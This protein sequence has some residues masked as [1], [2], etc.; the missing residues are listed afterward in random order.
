MDKLFFVIWCPQ[1]HKPVTR[2][3]ENIGQA[4]VVR[5]KLKGQFADRDFHILISIPDAVM[6]FITPSPSEGNTDT[7]H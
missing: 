2:K 3:F 7:E 1:S 5:D 6:A 4:M